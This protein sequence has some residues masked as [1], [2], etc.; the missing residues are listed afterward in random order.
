MDGRAHHV[1][2]QWRRGGAVRGPV[3]GRLHFQRPEVVEGAGPR[4]RP[5]PDDRVRPPL[6]VDLEQVLGAEEAQAHVEEP[7]EQREHDER[8]HADPPGADLD[9]HEPDH[10]QERDRREG[11]SQHA[12]RAVDLGTKPLDGHGDAF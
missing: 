5:V 3:D 11:A 4:F 9:A 10:E 2:D 8:G 6:H 7:G 1:L 12:A